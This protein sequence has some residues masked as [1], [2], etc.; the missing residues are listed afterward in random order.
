MYNKKSKNDKQLESR[1][2]NNKQRTKI[3]KTKCK[4]R[5]KTR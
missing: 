1:V 2:A 4:R 3:A 5:K